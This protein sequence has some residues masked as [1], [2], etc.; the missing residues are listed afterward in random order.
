MKT[1]LSSSGR[2]EER[3]CRRATNL[4]TLIFHI[5]RP[6]TVA[7]FAS[8][9]EGQPLYLEA[10]RSREEHAAGKEFSIT[11]SRVPLYGLFE[12]VGEIWIRELSEQAAEFLPVYG[13]KTDVKSICVIPLY[14]DPH[15]Q[16]VLVVDFT[17]YTEVDPLYRIRPILGL[18]ER[19]TY[20][21][22]D[23]YVPVNDLS[24][25]PVQV[26]LHRVLMSFIGYIQDV[27]PIRSMG[28]LIWGPP[29]VKGMVLEVV[30]ERHG[31]SIISG[32]N[33]FNIGPFSFSWSMTSPRKAHLLRERMSGGA[34]HFPIVVGSNTIGNLTIAG[35]LEG[36]DPGLPTAFIG[37]VSWCIEEECRLIG[38]LIGKESAIGA[39]LV[40]PY[41]SVNRLLDEWSN[42]SRYNDY[43]SLGIVQLKLKGLDLIRERGAE[44]DNFNR[45]LYFEIKEVLRK[46][47]VLI[48]HSGGNLVV[49]FPHTS[50][51]GAE[52]ALR[53]LQN[54]LEGKVIYRNSS[55]VRVQDA[56]YRILSYPRDLPDEG[57]VLERCSRVFLYG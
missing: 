3:I 5:L 6:H 40:N 2:E 54:L 19:L 30:G 35:D 32:A 1:T 14:L 15:K 29:V 52:S 20:H 18:L 56:E 49:I 39:S 46:G 16:W 50:P 26:F 23:V 53:R 55:V 24:K 21:R 27:M 45:G 44:L 9:G 34:R 12:D 41:R 51:E 38:E 33:S 13:E 47:D 17:V 11:P 8:S 25:F 36:V 37:L 7:L 22:D 28:C 4:V 42:A 31:D 43:L 48:H 10:I 57:A